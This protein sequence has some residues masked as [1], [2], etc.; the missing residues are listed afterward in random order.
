[1]V[2]HQ[3]D[4]LAV[5]TRSMPASASRSIAIGAVMSLPRAM[6]TSA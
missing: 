2:R 1:M 4:A 3:G 5:Q 6:S